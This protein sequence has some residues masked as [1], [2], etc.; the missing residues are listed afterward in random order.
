MMMHFH[1]GGVGH[2]STWQATDWFLSDRDKL[3]KG[4]ETDAEEEF[5]DEM[6]DMK[7]KDAEFDSDEGELHADAEMEDTEIEGAEQP[8][9][10]LDE[11]AYELD[12]IEEYGYDG[13][14]EIEESD[15]NEDEDGG[16]DGGATSEVDDAVLGAE[17]GEDDDDEADDYGE[18]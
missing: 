4:G 1:G 16:D 15:E 18:L 5:N 17:D 6:D 3:D 10:D 8:G 11:E 7:I 13:I 2:K 12:E 14:E 9:L